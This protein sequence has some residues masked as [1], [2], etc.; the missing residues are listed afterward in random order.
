MGVLPSADANKTEMK[1]GVVMPHPLLWAPLSVQRLAGEGGTAENS[2]PPHSDDKC[3]LSVEEA[4]L[5]IT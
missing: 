2:L 3:W 1:L 5:E 4:P